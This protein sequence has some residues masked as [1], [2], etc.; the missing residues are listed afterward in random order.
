M[1]GGDAGT[2]KDKTAVKGMVIFSQVGNVMQGD[3]DVKSRNPVL[4]D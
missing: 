1:S 4:F 2:T 3:G